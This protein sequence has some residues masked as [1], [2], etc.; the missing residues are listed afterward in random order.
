MIPQGCSKQMQCNFNK[1]S[2]DC[3]DR[4]CTSHISRNRGHSTMFSTTLLMPITLFSRLYI[5]SL[6]C[7]SHPQ[8]RSMKLLTRWIVSREGPCGSSQ[9]GSLSHR[10][11]V[12]FQWWWLPCGWGTSEGVLPGQRTRTGSSTITPFSWSL[13]WCSSTETVSSPGYEGY[14]SSWINDHWSTCWP[15]LSLVS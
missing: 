7:F 2:C 8:W 5:V 3:C 12:W 9:A 15:L 4:V 14:T 1:Y 11:L 13:E 10:S 6:F